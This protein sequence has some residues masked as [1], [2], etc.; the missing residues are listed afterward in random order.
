M[1]YLVVENSYKREI[2]IP[3]DG[4]R[5]KNNDLHHNGL[6][7]GKI[8]G[9]NEC[10]HVSAGEGGRQI[11]LLFKIKRVKTQMFFICAMKIKNAPLKEIDWTIDAESTS[12]FRCWINE[13]FSCLSLFPSLHGVF[14]GL[15]WSLT[16]HK[17]EKDSNFQ[18]QDLV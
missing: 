1:V 8:F 7:L 4:Y 2:K 12:S 13:F 9:E 6:Q 5:T 10:W 15:G 16:E 11:L 14:L 18:L 17:K 3:E